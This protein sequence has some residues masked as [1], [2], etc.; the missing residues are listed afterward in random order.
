MPKF[1]ASPLVRA[2]T[3]GQMRELLKDVS[4][5]TPLVIAEH[6][7]EL[8]SVA[9]VSHEILRESPFSPCG[10]VVATEKEA[11]DENLGA[12]GDVVTA[13]VIR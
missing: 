2:F 4:D 11:N 7:G 8:S 6:F 12:E 1:S 3:A 10:F 5:E 13:V 9:T